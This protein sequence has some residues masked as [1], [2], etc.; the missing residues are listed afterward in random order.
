M[1]TELNREN[2]IQDLMNF[3]KETNQTLSC[4]LDEI[5][6]TENTVKVGYD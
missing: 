5:E 6:W 3:S 2:I 1:D 4:I